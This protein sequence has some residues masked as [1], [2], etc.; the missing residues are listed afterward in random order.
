M[1]AKPCSR[2]R[3]IALAQREHICTAI[4][5]EFDH[6][7][8]SA[9]ARDVQRGVAKVASSININAGLDQGFGG[10]EIAPAHNAVKG[11]VASNTGCIH[12]SKIS[13]GKLHRSV[14]SCK[15]RFKLAVHERGKQWL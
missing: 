5:E 15:Y 6:L 9:H 1:A 8:V 7:D 11:I 12:V 14:Q 13:V 4:N 3:R 2:K 10:G